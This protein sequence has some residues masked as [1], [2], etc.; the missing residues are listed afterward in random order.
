LKIYDIFDSIACYD[1]VK[2][3]K[4]HP[5][6]LYKILDELDISNN[7]S[8]FIGDGN[9]DKIA[10]QRADIDYIMVN[11]GFSN[12]QEAISSVDKLSHKLIY[13]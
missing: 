9:R 6:M 5:D 3:G 7:N 1:E 10:A 12:H 4:P 13:G 2:M 8:I 11:W